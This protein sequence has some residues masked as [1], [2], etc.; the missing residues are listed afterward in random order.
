MF[1]VQHDIEMYPLD[2]YVDEVLGDELGILPRTAKAKT[3]VEVSQE[4]TISILGA[5]GTATSS[6][7]RIIMSSTE[8]DFVAKLRKILNSRRSRQVISSLLSQIDPSDEPL[9]F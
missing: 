9:P 5:T 1:T 8:D 6:E 4:M 2:I 7:P 3:L